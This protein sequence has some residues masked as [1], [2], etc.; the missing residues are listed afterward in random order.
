MESRPEKKRGFL[1]HIEFW[2]RTDKKKSH[3]P[4][5]LWKKEKAESP[6]SDAAAAAAENAKGAAHATLPVITAVGIE[7]LRDR[8]GYLP[9]A[10][11]GI[12]VTVGGIVIDALKAPVCLAI[13]TEEAIRAGITKLASLVFEGSPT[14]RQ[15]D[16]I[17]KSFLIRMR[18]T[19]TILVALGLE[20]KSVLNTKLTNGDIEDLVGLTLLHTAYASRRYQ[21]GLLLAT[22][23]ALIREDCPPEGLQLF[24]KMMDLKVAIRT[25][26]DNALQGEPLRMD[27]ERELEESRLVC[28]W[29][30]LIH[31]GKPLH[32]EDEP[33][34]NAEQMA[35][36]NQIIEQ[37][38][39]LKQQGM[40]VLPE[41]PE[42]VARQVP[43]L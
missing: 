43:R 7:M 39:D 17:F 2:K 3:S 33:D 1:N 14:E 21:G 42:K 24:D 11:L 18:D 8:G 10:P 6:I 32:L 40:A 22:N 23:K 35:L 4:F 31:A 27:D 38:Q 16:R 34:V 36:I 20:D 9:L 26:I 37:I 28:Q 30:E 13:A 15:V 25:A 29:I 41:E 19:A 5:F 12:P